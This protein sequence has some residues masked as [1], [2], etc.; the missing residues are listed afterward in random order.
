M[1]GFVLDASITLVWLL[2]DETNA[3][4]EKALEALGQHGAI[5]PALWQLEVRNSL[6]VAERRKRITP[7][8]V[9][10]RLSALSELPIALDDTPDH[11]L[12]T[13]LARKHQL[14]YYDAIYLELAARLS[15]PLAS[16]DKRLIKASADEGLAAL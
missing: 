8:E 5:V 3:R 15:M 7:A 6:L 12:A 2:D 14:S 9:D 4:A 16:L 13:A 11:A 10:E 1:S